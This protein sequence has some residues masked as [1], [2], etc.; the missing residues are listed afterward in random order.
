V[1]VAVI[2]ATC[3]P[4]FLIASDAKIQENVYAL[5]ETPNVAKL[6]ER[7]AYAVFALDK[8]LFAECRDHAAKKPLNV[9]VSISDVPFLA[10]IRCHVHVVL[11]V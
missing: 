9:S 8:K 3:T 6:P 5:A 11:M 7:T 10:M 4:T 2:Y 1:H